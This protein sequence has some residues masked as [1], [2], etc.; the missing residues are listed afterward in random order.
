MTWLNLL[1]FTLISA[2]MFLAGW[3]LGKWRAEQEIARRDAMFR[4][5]ESRRGRL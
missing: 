4:S 5:W 3:A 1:G 2:S